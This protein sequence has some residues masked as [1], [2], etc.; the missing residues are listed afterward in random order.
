MS[1]LSYVE[2]E[3]A[4]FVLF[5]HTFH[6]SHVEKALLRQLQV[7]SARIRDKIESQL[8]DRSHFDADWLCH[9]LRASSYLEARH[10][11][12]LTPTQGSNLSTVF[13]KLAAMNDVLYETEADID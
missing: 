3:R 1:A 9:T 13:N 6:I 2:C 7:C 10:A 4:S 5:C 8:H 11:A 12:R